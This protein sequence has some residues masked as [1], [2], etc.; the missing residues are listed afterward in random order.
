VRIID[1]ILNNEREIHSLIDLERDIDLFEKSILSKAF[2]GELRTNN[3][4]RKPL[5]S[6][7]D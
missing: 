1:R 3:S 4:V 6:H 7:L 2:Q 5:G